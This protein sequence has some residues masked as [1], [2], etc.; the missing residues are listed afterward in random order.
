MPARKGDEK[1]VEG[2]GRFR[3]G[4]FGG[5]YGRVVCGGG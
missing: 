1:A 2:L 3:E 5:R 4:V